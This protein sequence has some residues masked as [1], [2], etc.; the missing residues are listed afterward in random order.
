M[1]P[2]IIKNNGAHYS[3][4]KLVSLM[5][6]NPNKLSVSRVGTEEFS[7]YYVKYDDALFYLVVDDV[8]EFIGK[9]AVLNT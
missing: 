2:L 1:K 4:I 9:T 8:E 6:F 5:D 3:P 7:I